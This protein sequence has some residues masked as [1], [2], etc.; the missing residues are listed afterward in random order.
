MNSHD[1]TT[2]LIFTLGPGSEQARRQWFDSENAA[3]ERDFNACCLQAVV[4]AGREAGFSLRVSSPGAQPLV[5]DASLDRQS[6]R[7]FR[8]RLTGAIDRAMDESAGPLVVVGTDTPGLTSKHLLAAQ[9]ALVSNPED[10]VVGPAADGGIYLLAAARPISDLLTGVRWRSARTLASLLEIL[11][12]AGR[13]VRLL[14]VL[15]DLDSR[16]DLERWLALGPN[17]E[18]WRN[19]VRRLLTAVRQVVEHLPPA[20]VPVQVWRAVPIGRAPPR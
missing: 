16:A 11:E 12:A 1:P 13:T 5:D 6:E 18:W 17:G 10:I 7:S 20:A 2:L 19:V 8:R 15:A 4:A 9:A 14:P 3:V